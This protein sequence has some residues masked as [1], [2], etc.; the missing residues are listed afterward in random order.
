M[1]K[2]SDGSYCESS[3]YI[4]KKADYLHDWEI[5]RDGNRTTYEYCKRCGIREKFFKADNQRYLKT[6][7]RDFLQPTG[8]TKHLFA[9]E[10]GEPAYDAL[11]DQ[12]EAEDGVKDLEI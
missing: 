3:L 9:K 1:Y 12:G 4:G 6:H 10:Y 7:K 5:I 8:A 2:A 11:K